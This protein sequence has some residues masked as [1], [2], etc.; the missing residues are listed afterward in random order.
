MK[1]EMSLLTLNTTIKNIPF[2]TSMRQTMTVQVFLVEWQNRYQRWQK[3]M[4]LSAATS[5][6][7]LTQK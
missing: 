6:W 3:R 1:G 7:F 5:T 4:L 2:A